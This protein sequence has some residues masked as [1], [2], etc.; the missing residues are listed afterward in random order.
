[1]AGFDWRASRCWCRLQREEEQR[2]Q[3]EEQRRRDEEEARRREAERL[4]LMEVQLSLLLCLSSPNHAWFKQS[5]P[6]IW[7]LTI[8]R[9]CDVTGCCCCCS[10]NASKRRLVSACVASCNTDARSYCADAIKT[11]SVDSTWNRSKRNTASANPGS[12]R[13]TSSGLETLTN[14]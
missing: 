11:S 1:M 7:I 14:G 4:R 13:T 6:Y 3:R 5:P 10:C 9:L 8:V 12:S 2:Q